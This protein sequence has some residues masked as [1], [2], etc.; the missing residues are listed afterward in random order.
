MSKKVFARIINAVTGPMKSFHHVFED[1]NVF[2]IKPSR[3]A[4]TRMPIQ[5][6]AMPKTSRIIPYFIIDVNGTFPEP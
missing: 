3:G 6:M 1:A 4:M 2:Y 5:M